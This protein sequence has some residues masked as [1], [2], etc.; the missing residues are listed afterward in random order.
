MRAPNPSY[1]IQLTDDEV[2]VLRRRVRARSAAQAEVLRIRIVLAAHDQPDCSNQQLA[3]TLGTCD[4][5]VRRWRRRWTETHSLAD[6]P[7]SGAPLRFSP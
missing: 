1:P 3:Q 5:M 4:R 7:R 2:A 6:A